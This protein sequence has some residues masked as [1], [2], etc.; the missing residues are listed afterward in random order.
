[1]KSAS[2]LPLGLAEDVLEYFDLPAH[3]E[4]SPAGLTTLYRAWCRHVP[5]DNARKLI[6]VRAGQSGP[7]RLSSDASSLRR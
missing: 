5:F 2:P 1:M 3:P 4:R 6:A 7:R